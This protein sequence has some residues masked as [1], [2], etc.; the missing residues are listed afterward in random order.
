[1]LQQAL[2]SELRVD[3]VLLPGLQAALALAG[4][5]L[6]EHTLPPACFQGL[7]ALLSY[8]QRAWGRERHVGLGPG[9]GKEDMPIH[10]DPDTQL[11]PPI[12]PPSPTWGRCCHH[13]LH[14]LREAQGL[15][16]VSVVMSRSGS[17]WAS[18]WVCA[19]PLKGVR[20]WS[21]EGERQMDFVL[22]CLLRQGFSL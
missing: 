20:E 13:P 16:G 10:R 19:V 8:Y 1:M 15:S 2:E 9:L 17:L 21:S 14:R 22:S 11:L 5:V 3:W 7:L 18:L 12:L 6:Q 4:S